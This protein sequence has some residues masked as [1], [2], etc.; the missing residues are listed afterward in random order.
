VIS[1]DW[2]YSRSKDIVPTGESWLRD[3]LLAGE[4]STEN[5]AKTFLK[6]S[7]KGL[8]TPQRVKNMQALD[9]DTIAYG[10]VCAYR[11]FAKTTQ[12]WAKLVKNTCYRM[13]PFTL[14]CGRTFDYASSQTD[15]VKSA[16]LSTPAIREVFGD[17][18]PTKYEGTNPAFSSKA[19]FFVHPKTGEPYAFFSPKGGGQQVNGSLVQLMNQMY[20]PSFIAVDDGED[21]EDVQ[22]EELRDKYNRWL[23]NALLPCVSEDRPSSRTHRW[24]ADDKDPRWK[25]P[26]RVWYQDTIKHEASEMANI[27]QSPEWVGNVFPQSERRKDG[28]LYTLVP[29]IITDAQ[30][31][32]EA[33]RAEARGDLDGYAMEKMCLP[34]AATSDCWSKDLF[35]YYTDD[36]V[37]L[38]DLPDTH[39]FII[40]D[41]AKTAKAKSAFTAGLC[42]A[43]QEKERRISLRALINQRLHADEMPHAMFDLALEMNTP[44]MYIELTGLE[45]IG[46]HLFENAA[47]QRGLDNWI[48][49]HWL[50]A[51]Q[52]T[53]GN[54]G[55]GKDA[56]K[57]ARGSMLLPLYRCGCVFHVEHLKNSALEKQELSFPK[58]ARW[59]ALD[60]AGYIPKVMRELG[61][62]WEPDDV[63]IANL[64]PFIL[65]HRRKQADLGRRIAMG[66]WRLA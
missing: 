3:V 27:L 56:A 28:K 55:H 41:P 49:F 20:R 13:E 40:V 65:D 44:D 5:F 22:N 30:V 26:W 15:N 21:R 24:K 59:D 57:R 63:R 6:E 10:Y 4:Q 46:Q 54:Y 2:K 66:S 38:N 45:E 60:T 1:V 7:F 16:V 8:W 18:K 17:M 25:P 32:E 19:F 62:Y 48:R 34:Q 31:R 42:V 53:G 52:G 39:K 29:E 51:R 35:K 9:D 12:L 14:F 47:I 58:C 50:D 33:A 11:S 36:K 23:Y 64:H 37:T 61:I 43:V